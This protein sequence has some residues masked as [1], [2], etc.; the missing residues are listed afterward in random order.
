MYRSWFSAERPQPTE[1]RQ[2]ASDPKGSQDSRRTRID[3]LLTASAFLALHARP[4]ATRSICTFPR[5]LGYVVQPQND[6]PLNG[7]C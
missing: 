1:S 2:T 5:H 7:P 6:W 4:H 3:E